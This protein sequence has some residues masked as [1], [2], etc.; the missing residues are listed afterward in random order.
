[1]DAEPLDVEDFSDS[2]LHVVVQIFCMYMGFITPDDDFQTEVCPMLETMVTV[3]IL[4][5]YG[6]PDG[7]IKKLYLF[8]HF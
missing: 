7:K 8:I 5:P 3:I 1:M 2:Y 6:M 4:Q